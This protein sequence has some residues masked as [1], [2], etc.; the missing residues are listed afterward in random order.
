MRLMTFVDL[1]CLFPSGPAGNMRW[2]YRLLCWGGSRV[3]P[4]G[5][6]STQGDALSR[7][8]PRPGAGLGQQVTWEQVSDPARPA[9][10]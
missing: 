9:G 7:G 6:G 1:I 8:E 5:A 3:G 2:R 10:S 4:A